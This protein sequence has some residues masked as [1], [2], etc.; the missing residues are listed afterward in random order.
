M[1][2]NTFSKILNEIQPY[3]QY[4]YFHVKG[5]PLLHPQ[6]DE[7]LDISYKK[8]FKVQ[9]TTNGTLIH[10]VGSKIIEKPALRQ[11][12][13][14]LH[15]LDGNERVINQEG[16]VASILDFSKE[17]IE[18]SKMII[19]LRLWDLD[20]DNE[21]NLEKKKN[22]LILQMIEDT[23]QLDY[24]IEEKVVPG[25]GIKVANRIFVNQESKFQWPDLNA[26]EAF[27]PGFC[28]GLRNQVAILVDGTVVPCCLDGEGVM[29]LG[30]VLQQ[31]FRTIIEGERAISIYE[32]FSRK[33]V[34][35]ELCR[36]C[37]YRHRFL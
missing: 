24:E 7:L 21:A 36:K 8:G 22:R 30:N 12:N 4:I 35:E 20:Q 17:A 19:S 29:N 5:E 3:T 34:I 11:M 33:E 1:D 37:G 13:F 10:K 2:V 14:S 31:E 9:I 28:Y 26:D 16:Y 23:F 25:R 32:G 27:G 6:I 18:K 15:S